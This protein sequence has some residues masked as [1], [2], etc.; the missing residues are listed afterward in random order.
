MCQPASGWLLETGKITW[1]LKTESHSEIAKEFKLHEPLQGVKGPVAAAFEISP[2][3]RDYLL[4]LD[5]WVYRLDSER[6]P[7]WYDP[8]S[9]EELVRKWLPE[10]LSAK[11]VLPSEERTLTSDD[12]VLAVYGNVSLSGNAQV[13]E[14]YDNARVQQVSDNAQV[15]YVYDNAQVHYVYDNARV[16]QVSGNAQVH[17]VSDNAR[18]QQVSG[19]AQ[20]HEVYDNARVQ[21][22][23]GNAQVQRVSGNAQVHEV[24]GNAQVQRVYGNAQVHEVLG[25][26]IVV[27]STTLDPAILKS[28]GSVLIDRQ[29]TTPRIW[30]GGI[31][32]KPTRARKAK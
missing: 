32:F 15:H 27:A 3:D 12:I 10:W 22:V 7:E 26:A 1:S 19:N 11:V 28:G 20:M 5:Q 24:S 4:P 13:H 25:S 30:V 16:Q 23:S 6:A 18:V 9:A 29:T 21:R 14:V 31:E 2:P 17:Y 8:T